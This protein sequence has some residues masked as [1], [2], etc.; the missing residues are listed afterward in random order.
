MLTIWG[1]IWLA[2]ILLLVGLAIHA[3]FRDGEL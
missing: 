3:Y 1:N 2:V